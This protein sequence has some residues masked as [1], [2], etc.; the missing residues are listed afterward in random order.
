MPRSKGYSSLSADINLTDANATGPIVA[1][2]SWL[3]GWSFYLKD[4]HPTVTQAF[5]EYPD[6]T[7]AIQSP[8]KL[9]AGPATIRFTFDHDAGGLQAGG[10]V[11]MWVNGKPVGEGRVEKTILSIAGSGESFDIGFDSG[12]PVTSDYA[13]GSSFPGEI[14]KLLVDLGPMVTPMVPRTQIGGTD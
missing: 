9:A 14:K 6:E 5:S 13:A 4:G 8:V 1:D 11:R 7:Y 2:G 3:G 10:T 12:S